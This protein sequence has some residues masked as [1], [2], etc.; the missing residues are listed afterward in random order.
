MAAAR[1][2]LTENALGIELPV[3]QPRYQHRPAR[4]VDHPVHESDNFVSSV[5]S[6]F[7]LGLNHEDAIELYYNPTVT[8]WLSISPSLQII[9]PALNKALDSSGNFKDLDTTYIAGVRVGVRF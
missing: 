2:P 5:R 3:G 1:P 8:P 6:T 7:D 4:R 9:S